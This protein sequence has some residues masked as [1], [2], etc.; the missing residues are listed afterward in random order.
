MVQKSLQ[1]QQNQTFEEYYNKHCL[2]DLVVY[3]G[4]AKLL[5]SLKDDFILTVATNANSI[6]P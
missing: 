1:K 6:C 5:E 3:D 2:S 4:I